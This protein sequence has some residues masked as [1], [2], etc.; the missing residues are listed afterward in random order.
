MSMKY[1][2]PRLVEHRQPQGDHV[3][4]PAEAP[5]GSTCRSGARSGREGRHP[6]AT[7]LRVWIRNVLDA[8]VRVHRRTCVPGRSRRLGVDRAGSLETTS[9]TLLPNRLSGRP[10]PAGGEREVE[11]A[12]RTAAENRGSSGGSPPAAGP[13]LRSP[14]SRGIGP[15]EGCSVPVD[16]QVHGAPAA[17]ARALIHQN[18]STCGRD[19]ADAELPVGVRPVEE[20][21]ARERRH[22]A[23]AMPRHPASAFLR[24]ARDG[25]ADPAEHGSTGHDGGAVEVRL[26]V[27]VVAVERRGEEPHAPSPEDG[28]ESVRVVGRVD[29]VEVGLQDRVSH[30]Q[31]R[32]VRRGQLDAP[33]SRGNSVS[34][35]PSAL[36]Q[37]PQGL[38]PDLPVRVH[39]G[40]ALDPGEVGVRVPAGPR[41]SRHGHSAAP[42]PPGSPAWRPEPGVVPAVFGTSDVAARPPCRAGQPS[43]SRKS[44]AYQSLQR[45]AHRAGLMR[46]QRRDAV[47]VVTR[48]WSTRG[49]TRG[50]RSTASSPAS[51]DRKF[52]SPVA[53]RTGTSA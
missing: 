35:A 38:E 7:G 21:R 27:H 23:P 48:R 32:R 45:L 24:A 6:C 4:A 44:I 10:A 13:R 43:L 17:R 15:V 25:V 49:R 12:S 46:V 34:A 51:P 3:P 53:A 9:R 16:H 36:A 20:V 41:R 19:V 18:R 37:L 5:A 1:G 8:A 52:A 28:P 11:G 22:V 42:T 40:T 26:R 14:P 50:R 30:V 29:E 39:L 33:V 47:G 2:L 31:E